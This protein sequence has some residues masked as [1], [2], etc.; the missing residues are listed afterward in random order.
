[1]FGIQLVNRDVSWICTATSE[2]HGNQELGPFRHERLVIPPDKPSKPAKLLTE[3]K[4][5]PE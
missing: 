4:A 2:E 3:N 1:M 5:N